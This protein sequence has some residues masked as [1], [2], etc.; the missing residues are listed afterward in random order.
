MDKCFETHTYALDIFKKNMNE[1]IAKYSDTGRKIVMFGT[2]IIAEIIVEYLNNTPLDVSFIV[3]NDVKRQGKEVYGKIVYSPEKLKDNYNDNYLIFIASSYQDEMISQ[4]ESY[5]YMMNKHIIKVIDLPELMSDY[6]YVD[7]SKMTALNATQIRKVLLGILDNL[8]KCCEKHG[9]RYYLSSGTALG[10]IRHEGFIPWDD[11]VDVFM[12]VEDFIALTTILES[13]KNYGVV[14]Q[15]NSDNYLGWG[16]GYIVD[17]HT[18]CDINKFPIQLTTG[19]EIDLFPLYGLPDDPDE[20]KVYIKRAKQ[21]ETKCLIALQDEDRVMAIKEFNEF[22][23][24]YKYDEC[25]KV[26][27]ILMPYFLKDVFDKDIFG[28]GVK[29]KFENL[30][31]RMPDRWDEYLTQV[32]GNYMELPP[33]EKRVGQHF[34][35]TYYTR[36][37]R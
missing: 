25:N 19:Q 15:F 35:N 33:I 8:D 12:P 17:R 4:I 20:M 9:L 34:F 2:S 29:K 32:Y 31:L 24:S 1:I 13:D 30:E 36:K 11:D 7:R 37:D 23:L 10:A 22:L 27:N 18:I 28:K 5:G 16:S 6:S 3:D 21:L 14:S 26:G